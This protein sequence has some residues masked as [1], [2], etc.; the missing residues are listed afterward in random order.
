MWIA[1]QA[2]EAVAELLAGD[3]RIITVHG[4]GGAGSSSVVERAL[5]GVRHQRIDLEGC[6][7][8]AEA[9][10]R[11]KV[12]RRDV[13]WLDQAHRLSLARAAVASLAKRTSARVIIAGR[14]PLGTND[15]ACVPVSLLDA[16]STQRLLV[17]ELRRLGVSNSPEVALLA[18]RIGG[19]P[20]A[21]RSAATAV[22]TLGHRALAR[23]GV[24]QA[25]LDARCRAVLEDVWHELPPQD[26]DLLATLATAGTTVD[27]GDA[28]TVTKDAM[29]SLGSLTDR[30]LIVMPDTRIGLSPLVASFVRARISGPRRA[31]AQRQYAALILGDAERARDTFRRDPVIAGRTLELLSGELLAICSYPAAR[32]AVRAALAIE[33]LL[34]GRLERDVVLDVW[35]KAAIA[36]ATLDEATRA[37]V[38]LAHARTLIARGE[39]ESAEELLLCMPKL[40]RAPA[41]S[42][43]RSIYLGHIAAWRGALPR[44]R[45][46]LDE[47]DQHLAAPVPLTD[48]ERALDAREDA[49][50]QRAFVAFQSGDLDE[51]ERLCRRCA[52]EAWQR[53]SLR[54]VSL[55]RRLSAEVMLRRGAAEQAAALFERTRDELMSY[56]DRA[57]ALFLWSRLVEALRVAGHDARAVAEARAAGALAARTGE[58]ALELAVLGVLDESDVAPARVAEL[59]WRAQIPAVRHD[60]QAWL[61]K[62]AQ[63]EPKRL[64]RLDG[65][66]K[67]ATLGDLRTPLA[68]RMTLWRM[69]EALAAAHPRA[70]AL[71]QDSLFEIGWPNEQVEASSKKKRVQTA[72]WALRRLLLGDLLSTLPHGYALSQQIRVERT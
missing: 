50:L 43:W 68:R 28:I 38:A 51:T 22:R 3:A 49:R 67:L 63:T 21:L 44:A 32:T 37:Q 13:V 66:S 2:D 61:G 62:R 46:F 7:S 48:L 65:T 29:R 12:I 33:P 42:A 27:A 14:Q 4:L 31:R 18:V 56:G 39:H 6:R 71:S 59:A 23:R 9:R 16:E 15:E 10:R 1:R 20:L 54:M 45:A 53:P 58:G 60:A 57:G 34:T 64:L 72:I 70:V 41:S 26:K 19:W 35:K 55:A 36:A 47:A 17:S 69:L 24:L 8:L 52:D 30:G 11:V 5:G 40:R 25:A